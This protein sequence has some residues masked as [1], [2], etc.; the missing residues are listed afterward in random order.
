[1]FCI[2][3]VARFFGFFFVLFCNYRNKLEQLQTENM[4]LT[5]ANNDLHKEIRQLREQVEILEA[6]NNQLNVLN[7]DLTNDNT[8]Y[9]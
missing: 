8:S 5:N 7:G 6:D 1:M 4:K 9:M 3:Y 2:L